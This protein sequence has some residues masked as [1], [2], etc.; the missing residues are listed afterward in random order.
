MWILYIN[1]G[2]APCFKEGLV[3]DIKK[4][5][6]QYILCDKNMNK[7]LQ[8]EQMDLDVNYWCAGNNKV[9]ANYF[10][11]QFLHSVNADNIVAAIEAA[12]NI[13][14]KILFD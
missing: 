13:A 14:Y 1:F 11:S 6:F 10:D 12:L 5:P 8:V 9:K 2:L 3:H 7:I 4:S